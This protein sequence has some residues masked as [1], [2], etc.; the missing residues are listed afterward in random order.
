MKLSRIRIT[1]L[2]RLLYWPNPP[3]LLWM[4]RRSSHHSHHS[5][6]WLAGRNGPEWI[7]STDPHTNWSQRDAQGGKRTNVILHQKRWLLQWQTLE[8]VIGLLDRNVAASVPT[9]M[10]DKYVFFAKHSRHNR[11]IWATSWFDTSKS[12]PKPQNSA[13]DERR[14]QI[15]I[16]LTKKVDQQRN[17]FKTFILLQKRRG[18][19]GML[20]MARIKSCVDRGD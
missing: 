14:G 3:I 6:H 19:P 20:W 15:A 11:N 9:I 1:V 4:E 16:V 2:Y 18:F 10:T 5:S 13:V 8:C 17:T 12:M 7:V